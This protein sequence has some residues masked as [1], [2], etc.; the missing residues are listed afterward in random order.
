MKKVCQ[1]NVCHTIGRA[2]VASAPERA[3]AVFCSRQHALD[4]RHDEP[5][6]KGA[7]ILRPPLARG[8]AGSRSSPSIRSEPYNAVDARRT[9][10]RAVSDL[11]PGVTSRPPPHTVKQQWDDPSMAVLSCS[12]DQASTSHMP[13]PNIMITDPNASATYPETGLG[14]FTNP[15]LDLYSSL[16]DASTQG[17]VSSHHCGSLDASASIHVPSR[18]RRQDSPLDSTNAVDNSHQNSSKSSP[19]SLPPPDAREDTSCLVPEE[20][21]DWT[22]VEELIAGGCD[23]M[24]HDLYTQTTHKD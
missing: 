23:G 20:P 6:I 22:W 4:A 15:N 8:L 3:P 13:I 19:T 18:Y 14:S 24:A 10:R 11:S 16:Q 2:A 5:K 17:A 1:S 9:V 7:D 12:A 21:L